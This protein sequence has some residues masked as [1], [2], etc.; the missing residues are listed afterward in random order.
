MK[1]KLGLACT[2]VGE[3]KVLLLD[4]PVWVSTHF[5]SRTVANGPRTGG[6]RHADPLEYVVSG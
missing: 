6:R 2:L 4:E 1:Q 3:P 5:P